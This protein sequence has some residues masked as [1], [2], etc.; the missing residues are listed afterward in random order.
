MSPGTL[1]FEAIFEAS[2][3][4]VVGEG[5]GGFRVGAQQGIYSKMLH[6]I[7]IQCRSR[8]AILGKLFKVVFPSAGL[9]NLIIEFFQ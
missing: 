9:V 6:V 7:R 3:F 1:R 4:F 8:L 5:G 2:F